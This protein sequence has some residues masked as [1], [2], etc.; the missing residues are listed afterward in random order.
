MYMTLYVYAV[1]GA[2][3]SILVR[4]NVVICPNGANAKCL[5]VL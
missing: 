2:T 4:E 3:A 1:G 5:D